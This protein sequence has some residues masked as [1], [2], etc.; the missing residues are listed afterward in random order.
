MWVQSG[1][2]LWLCLPAFWRVHWCECAGSL[3]YFADVSNIGQDTAKCSAFLSALPLC[4]WSVTLEYGSISR[5]KGVFSAVCGV[6]V[7]LF[8][9]RALRGLCGFCVREWLGGL[10]ACGVF[11]LSF[12]L[13]VPVFLSFSLFAYLLGLCLCCSLL[14]LLSVLFVLVCL[15]SLL[16]PF[17]FRTKRKKSAFVLR[18]FFAWFWCLYFKLSKAVIASL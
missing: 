14:V 16:F 5:F 13:F 3:C 11:C 6:C 9:W 12:S 4:L 17:P 18:S 15:W 8:A 7:G 1:C 2:G 10:E